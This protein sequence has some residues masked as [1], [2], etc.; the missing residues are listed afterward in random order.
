VGEAVVLR[1]PE[2]TPDRLPDGPHLLSRAMS[3]KLPPALPR[4]HEH[5]VKQKY[6]GNRRALR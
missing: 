3:W 6:S 4:C 2:E 5:L 1:R